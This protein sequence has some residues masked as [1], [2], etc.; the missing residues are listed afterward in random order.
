MVK[1]RNMILGMGSLA[2]GSG[3]VLG[4]SASGSSVEPSADMRVI[5][6]AEL[7][8]SRGNG[9][10]DTED[11]MSDE[12]I[13]NGDF[14]GSPADL[15]L[16][17][18]NDED[19]EELSIEIAKRNDASGHTWTELI[20][21]DNNGTSEVEIRFDYTSYS[22]DIDSTYEETT[23]EGDP[24]DRWDAQEIFQF[25]DS[26]GNRLSPDDDSDEGA[27]TLIVGGGET[28]QITLVT[29]MNEH[30][31][32]AVNDETSVGQPWQSGGDT[33]G[34]QFLEEITIKNITD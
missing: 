15:P 26:E 3:A 16:A 20:A 29:D 8:V 11:D 27:N 6:A 4:A 33:D 13:Y 10:D 19:N 18:V 14:D 23:S 31:V 7:T 1:R 22:D 34:V 21:V 12:S 30:Q 2:V 24:L 9:W 28:E 17:F 25:E 32:S 5:A